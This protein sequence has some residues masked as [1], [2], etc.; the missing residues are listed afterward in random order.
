MEKYGYFL[1]IFEG[2][3]GVQEIKKYCGDLGFP[4]TKA[5]AQGIVNW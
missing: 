3:V 5:K 2:Y 4:I 1:F